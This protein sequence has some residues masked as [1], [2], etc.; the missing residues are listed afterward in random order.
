MERP[1]GS[2]PLVGCRVEYNG[3]KTGGRKVKA[4]ITRVV[5]ARDVRLQSESWFAMLA[6]SRRAVMGVRWIDDWYIADIQFDDGTFETNVEGRSLT[7]LD[8]D[9]LRS[10]LK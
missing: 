2:I 8:Q 4:R 5:D 3:P 9:K 10:K 7:I 6:K 1:K